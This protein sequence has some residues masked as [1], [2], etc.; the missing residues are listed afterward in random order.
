VLFLFF[1]ILYVEVF[2]LTKWG[3]VETPT[4]NYYSLGSA[5]VMLSFRSTGFVEVIP[6][7]HTNRGLRCV[8]NDLCR[9]TMTTS[10]KDKDKSPSKLRGSPPSHSQSSSLASSPVSPLG[11]HSQGQ[12]LYG[13]H[14]DPLVYWA[15]PGTNPR[16]V[17]DSSLPWWRA[18][19]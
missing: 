13:K 1:A 19:I 18:A 10:N 4:T 17:Y 16:D 5:S 8:T 9:D 7:R 2:G 15:P 3:G 6:E 11:F 12:R 14:E